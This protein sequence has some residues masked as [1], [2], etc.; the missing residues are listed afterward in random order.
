M[1][2]VWLNKMEALSC[3]RWCVLWFA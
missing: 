1:I 3:K 2:A